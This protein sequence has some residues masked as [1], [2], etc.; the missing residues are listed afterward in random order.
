LLSPQ[1]WAQ[2]RK[3]IDKKQSGA[4]ETTTGTH[5][6][7]FWG[8]RQ[9]TRMTVPVKLGTNVAY[10]QMSSGYEKF[11]AFCTEMGN[12]DAK[13][14]DSNPLNED[15]IMALDA[16]VTDDEANDEEETVAPV[17][18]KTQVLI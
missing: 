6:T 18:T 15:D 8:N 16:T 1:H 14:S 13:T 4:G 10:F 7:L 2:S 17:L 5:V 3:G 11:Q 9:Y 12:S